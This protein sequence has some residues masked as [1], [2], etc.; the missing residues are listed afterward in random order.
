MSP[1]LQFS[2]WDAF[3]DL[4]CS[5]LQFLPV[6]NPLSVTFTSSYWKTRF[7]GSRSSQWLHHWRIFNFWV[8]FSVCLG[9]L[10]TY[11]C[12]SECDQ[13]I[14]LDLSEFI[15]LLRFG[16]CMPEN[17]SPLFQML[18]GFSEHHLHWTEWHGLTLTHNLLMQ[19]R[20]TSYL[21]TS[22]SSLMSS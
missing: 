15:F 18:T 12:I 8:S 5:H 1:D 3:S 14:A 11:P 9:S 17:P 19:T 13:S 21:L 6:C 7:V 4:H 20:A 16:L 10:S 22:A 2:S